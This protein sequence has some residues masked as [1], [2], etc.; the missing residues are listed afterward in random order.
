[1]ELEPSEINDETKTVRILKGDEDNSI[2]NDAFFEYSS[3]E[4]VHIEDRANITYIGKFAF[5]CCSSLKSIKIP[6]GVK[7]IEGCTFKKCS[8]LK[9]IGI[10][11]G[12][13]T[14]GWNAFYKCSSLRS[15]TIPNSVDYIGPLACDSCKL[16]QSIHIPNT[17]ETI[18]EGAFYGCH[19]LENRLE[20][21]TNYHPCIYTWLCRRFDNL[22]IHQACYYAND[23][24][25]SGAVD[26]LSKLIQ[27]NHRALT[28]TDAMGMTPL[29]I[30]CCNPH[31]TVEMVRVI[32]EKEEDASRLLA[33]T[34][35]T[36]S[37]P[38]QL[39]MQCRGYELEEEEKY[40]PWN[41][42]GADEEEDEPTLSLH[43]LLEQGIS[44]EDLSIVFALKGNQQIDMSL[45]HDEGTDLSTFMSAVMLSAYG[46]DVVFALAMYDLSSMLKNNRLE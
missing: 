28:A 13:T 6:I 17:V 15:I 35:V 2:P 25:Q 41:L 18:E 22:P 8:S 19:T 10:P 44:G 11:I 34:D 14:I 12:V 3:L 31:I 4:S 16:L 20:N 36:G 29:H 1:M 30:L 27:E 33:H 5:Y 38:L 40:D 21:G 43:D 37:T 32:V 45:S 46:L 42:F 7:S 39:F 24:A 9:L 23:D 26:H